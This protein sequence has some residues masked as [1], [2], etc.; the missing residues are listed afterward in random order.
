MISIPSMALLNNNKIALVWI[1]NT[2]LY[3]LI[4]GTEYGSVLTVDNIKNRDEIL[5][6]VLALSNGNFV[7]VWLDLDFDIYA[8]VYAEIF[9]TIKSNNLGFLWALDT[10]NDVFIYQF[11]LNTLKLFNFQL[12]LSY[13]Q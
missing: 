8:K 6:D 10:F 3:T 4:K 5:F 1:N 12:V 13:D 2:L 9:T 11:I 7:I